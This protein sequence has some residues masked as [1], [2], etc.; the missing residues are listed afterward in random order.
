MPIRQNRPKAQN[1]NRNTG[2]P[3]QLRLKD[4]EIVM[5][6]VYDLFYDVNTELLEKG[7]ER[8]SC[9]LFFC[10]RLFG[11]RDYNLIIFKGDSDRLRQERVM[12]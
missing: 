11:K 7:L 3:F 4:F 2:L 12:F 1:F 5:Q 8:L 9:F 10:V 6:D